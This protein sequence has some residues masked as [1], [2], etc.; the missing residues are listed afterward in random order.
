MQIVNERSIS[1]PRSVQGCYVLLVASYIGNEF[2]EVEVEFDLSSKRCV[3]AQLWPRDEA[4]FAEKPSM[5]GKIKKKVFKKSEKMQMKLSIKTDGVLDH[6]YGPLEGSR[7]QRDTL[8]AVEEAGVA[9]EAIEGQ[10]HK[11]SITKTKA[12][13]HASANND[14]RED[15][16]Q[17]DAAAKPAKRTQSDWVKQM[18]MNTGRY[19][20]W[21][22]KTNE[23]TWTQ[24]GSFSNLDPQSTAPEGAT[25][26]GDAKAW[27]KQ[28]DPASQSYY[29]WNTSTGE[30]SW[31][32]PIGFQEGNLS[33]ELSAATKIQATFRG[34][35]SRKEIFNRTD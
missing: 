34:Q 28:Y 31:D 5:L 20:Y 10:R 35:K 7:T 2:G 24:P 12:E 22:V 27:V 30:T 1:T 21:N 25:S 13:D 19:Y 26:S 23:T 16:A 17:K 18:D 15:H 29:Y 32:E 9:T 11:T 33:E 14:S 4:F 8:K 3:I 6:K